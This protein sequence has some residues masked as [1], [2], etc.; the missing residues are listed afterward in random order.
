MRSETPDPV[1]SFLRYH[2]EGGELTESN[3][4]VNSWCCLLSKRTSSCF[5]IRGAISNMTSVYFPY[6]F[7]MFELK[8]KDIKRDFGH[9]SVYLIYVPVWNCAYSSHSTLPVGVLM[10]VARFKN[11]KAQ[12]TREQ[13]DAEL[14]SCNM[15]VVFF[16]LFVASTAG[17]LMLFFPKLLG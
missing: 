11:Y 3:V 5:T 7:V 4:T 2:K 1:P 16:Q 6:L 8:K 15:R 10:L 17:V 14:F 12:I 9:V 13:E